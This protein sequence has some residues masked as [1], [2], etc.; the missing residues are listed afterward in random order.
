MHHG[1]AVTILPIG[2]V[3]S[4]CLDANGPS[5]ALPTSPFSAA[6]CSDSNPQSPEQGWNSTRWDRSAAQ[7][8]EPE[9][10]GMDS[11]SSGAF[12]PTGLIKPM[13]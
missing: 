6:K 8:P 7:R 3:R 1:S 13:D 10:T 5:E 11:P 9:H 12:Q 4:R 2:P